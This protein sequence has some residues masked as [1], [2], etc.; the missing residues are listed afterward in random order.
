MSVLLVPDPTA[1]SNAPITL[2][3]CEQWKKETLRRILCIYQTVTE[4]LIAEIERRILSHFLN[5]TTFSTKYMIVGNIA[6][7]C[8]K[9]VLAKQL[10]GRDLFLLPHM[11]TFT[12]QQRASPYIS[13][14]NRVG[15]TTSILQ[16]IASAFETNGFTV[17]DI[18]DGS[19]S[20][21]IVLQI[22]FTPKAAMV[23]KHTANFS[24]QSTK[25]R[26]SFT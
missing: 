5:P 23:P 7:I 13:Y 12:H 6:H 4:E 1:S 15:I 10:D 9:I 17:H 24:V 22:V 2:C 16:F 21:Y 14:F 19:R 11:L 25:R 20:H 8:R 26:V 3:Y 18:S